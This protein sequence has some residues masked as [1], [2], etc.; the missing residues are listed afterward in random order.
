MR[1]EFRAIALLWRRRPDFVGAGR[2]GNGPPHQYPSYA[3]GARRLRPVYRRRATDP[4]GGR[5]SMARLL[6]VE[7][8]FYDHL[9]DLLLEGARSALKGHEVEVMTVPG[10]RKSTRLNSSH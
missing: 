10:D 1:R 3:G 9:N 6:I 4:A 5:L 8:R 7:A 2:P